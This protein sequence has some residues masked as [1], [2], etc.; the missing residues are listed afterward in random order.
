[1]SIFK[2]FRKK[3]LKDAAD[4]LDIGKNKKALKILYNNLDDKNACAMLA[5]MYEHGEGVDQN[6]KLAMQMYVRA[7]KLGSAEA[8]FILGGFCS[9]GQYIS[10]SIEKAFVFYKEA[11][12]Q[13][14]VEAQY[15]TGLFYLFGHLGEKNLEAAFKYFEMGAMLGH[16]P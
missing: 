10:R 15:K 8:K 7:A 13:G 4:L 16:P 11:A 2:I 3:T 9:A 6:I 1:M 12:D 5:H 14:M